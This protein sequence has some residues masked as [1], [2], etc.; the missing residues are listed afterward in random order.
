MKLI[1]SP[2]AE[3]ELKKL[4]KIDQIA[5]ARKIRLIK[6]SFVV[7]EENKLSGYKNIFRVRI[8]QYRIVYRKTVEEVYIV[9]IGH[10]KDVY[11]MLNQLLR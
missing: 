9:L 11:R 10:R 2:R 7:P 6:Y 5:I 1:I 4:P 8:S 3:K